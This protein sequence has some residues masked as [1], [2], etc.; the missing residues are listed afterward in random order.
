LTFL[1]HGLM[2]VG[3]EIIFVRVLRWGKCIYPGRG[4]SDKGRGS[5][6]L[7][8]HPVLSHVPYNA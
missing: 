7:G 1:S 4:I 6:P 5:T 8:N 2:E 3:N